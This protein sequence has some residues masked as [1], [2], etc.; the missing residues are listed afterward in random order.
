MMYECKRSGFTLLELMIAM[1]VLTIAG[2][3]F[4]Y[5]IQQSHRSWE[6]IADDSVMMQSLR[7]AK[8]DIHLHF[9]QCSPAT[10][11]LTNAANWDRASFQ[12]P[13][14]LVAGTAVWGADGNASWTYRYQVENQSGTDVLFRITYNA[15]G[16]EIRRRDILHD[17]APMAFGNRGLIF[18]LENNGSITTTIGMRKKITGHAGDMLERNLQFNTLLRNR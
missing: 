7:R 4:Y 3:G 18:D 13:I 10:L 2:I 16:T 9:I 5:F 14:N 15:G 12:I 1:V 6:T 17:I 11:A 8:D